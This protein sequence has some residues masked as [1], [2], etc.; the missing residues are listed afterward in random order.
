MCL[1]LFLSTE[2]YIA[3]ELARL[4][5]AQKVRFVKMFLQIVVV[6]VEC[7]AIAVRAKVASIVEARQMVS[8]CVFVEEI[9]FA[10]LQ[11][12]ERI[13]RRTMD[14]AGSQSTTR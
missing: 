4:V 9:R 5:W 8:K 1:Q 12:R 3:L 13:L 11:V 6:F 2:G 7:K 10:E 14:V